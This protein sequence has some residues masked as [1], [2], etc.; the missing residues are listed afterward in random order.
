MI[1]LILIVVCIIIF[2][3]LNIDTI[4]CSKISYDEK[5]FNKIKVYV[6][7]SYIILLLGLIISLILAYLKFY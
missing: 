4:E 1:N 2:V 5:E 3:Y 6:I 7:I